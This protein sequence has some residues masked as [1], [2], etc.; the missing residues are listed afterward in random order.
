MMHW[1]SEPENILLNYKFYTRLFE[2]FQF[3]L[4]QNLHKPGLQV[5]A[6]IITQKWQLCAIYVFVKLTLIITKLQIPPTFILYSLVKSRVYTLVWCQT[7]YM[8]V[9]RKNIF[10]K[11]FFLLLNSLDRR[12]SCHGQFSHLKIISKLFYHS[13][14]INL[15]SLNKKSSYLVSW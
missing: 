15:G 13:I 4:P 8:N 14:C 1:K 3:K 5:H 2:N 12:Q 10:G 9:D 7:V 11:F 6:M